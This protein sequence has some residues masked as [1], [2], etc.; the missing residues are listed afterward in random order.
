M[1][2]ADV[3]LNPYRRM[4]RDFSFL[5]KYG[6]EYG[7]KFNHYIRPAIVYEKG[8]ESISI[9]F[10]YEDDCFHVTYANNEKD[11]HGTSML[12]TD[13]HIYLGNTYKEQLPIVK[14]LLKIKLENKK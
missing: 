2:W 4:K 9:S 6:Y 8:E 12:S 10:D 1:T 13:W 14:Y 3:F 5:N 11:L 7:G